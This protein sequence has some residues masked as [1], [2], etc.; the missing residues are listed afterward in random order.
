MTARIQFFDPLCIEKLQAFVEKEA[1]EQDPLYFSRIATEIEQKKRQ[2][3][4][5]QQEER[6]LGYVQINFQ[7]AY[8]A[9]RRFQ[10][11]ELQDLYVSLD[12]RQQ[13]YG[14]KLIQA[15]EN[16]C[17]SRGCPEIG[18]GVG[19]LS[20]FGAAQRL[21]VSMG[22]V[23]DGAGVVSNREPVA[24]GLIKPIDETFCLMMTKKLIA[25]A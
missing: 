5:L 8:Q 10:I 7:P 22:Y 6:I 23:P 20:K 24:Q 16:F 12:C 3:L 13:G 11:P 2:V 19:I 15:A 1:H 21:Y 14:K 25:L 9:F 17:Q 18:L 4:F